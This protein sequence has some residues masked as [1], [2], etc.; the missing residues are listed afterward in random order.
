M[1]SSQTKHRRLSSENQH[2]SANRGKIDFL[3][4]SVSTTK[5]NYYSDCSKNIFR[6]H[7][8]KGVGMLSI[9]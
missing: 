9:V 3:I 2:T 5:K 4:W 6:Q 8:L 7:I 1:N